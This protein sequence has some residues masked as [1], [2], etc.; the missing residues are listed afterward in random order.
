[1]YTVLLADD[2]PSIREGMRD[3]IEWNRLGYEL[4]AVMDDGEPVLASLKTNPPDVVITDIKMPVKSGLDVAKYVCENSLH[5]KILL[6]SGYKEVN[7]A[8]AAIQY[9]VVG[10][11]LKPVDIAELEE[12]LVKIKTQLD[13]EQERRSNE[14]VLKYYQNNLD[15]LKD[16]FFMELALGSFVN[17]GYLINMFQFL[18]PRLI[19]SQ[20]PC[21]LVTITF[22]DYEAFLSQRW[23]HTAG[24]LYVALSNCVGMY[25]GSVTCRMVHKS[26]DAVR[27]I[28]VATEPGGDA[29]ELAEQSVRLLCQCFRDC[30]SLQAVASP[31]EI[32][33]DIVA[34]SRSRRETGGSSDKRQTT[35]SEQEEGPLIE[36]AK[37]YIVEHIT[38]ELSLEDVA[39]KFYLSQYYFSRIFKAKTGENLIDFIIAQKMEKA[40]ELLRNPH[41]KVYEVSDMV[42]YRSKRYFTKVFKNHTGCT[43]SEYRSRLYPGKSVANE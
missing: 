30:F 8:M 41:Y 42:G 16:S 28:G 38:E 2:E 34:L 3:L 13:A 37:R 15:E 11:I 12:Q 17:E 20:C 7:L 26:K 21:F 32:Y 24:E 36:Q 6:I 27:I 43:P 5:T 10:Y 4:T 1:M 9:N 33:G 19:Y 35:V 25:G 18:Y 22:S 39:E 23:Q 29:A 40:K 14:F 31:P